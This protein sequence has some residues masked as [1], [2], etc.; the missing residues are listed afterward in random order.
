MAKHNVSYIG[1]LLQP[2]SAFHPHLKEADRRNTIP[3][4]RRHPI[5]LY[6]I[7]TQ[8]DA[9][10]DSYSITAL[11]SIVLYIQCSRLETC[12]WTSNPDRIDLATDRIS[13][14]IIIQ[15]RFTALLAG[16]TTHSSSTSPPR[17][18]CRSYTS[19]ERCCWFRVLHFTS[20]VLAMEAGYQSD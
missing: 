14:D 3:R 18:S 19:T 11:T 7:A 12:L 8:P 1:V 13:A 10:T 2:I 6:L 15:H 20:T 17:Q 9:V 4:A 5:H 16:M